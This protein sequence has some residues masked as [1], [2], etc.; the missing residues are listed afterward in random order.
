MGEWDL[1]LPVKSLEML[2]DL[3]GCDAVINLAVLGRRLFRKRL[4]E[5]VLHSD[6]HADRTFLDQAQTILCEFEN[7]YIRC[8]IFNTKLLIFDYSYCNNQ[9]FFI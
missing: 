2:M 8:V 5:A 7:L 9:K 1:D 4:S 3:A 6:S